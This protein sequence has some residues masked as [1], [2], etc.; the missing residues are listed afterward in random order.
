MKVLIVD[1]EKPVRE[2]IRY[3]VPWDK[4][5]IS[6]VYEATNGQEATAIMQEQQP[7]VVFTDMRMPLMD[8]AQ[9]LEWLH[10]HYPNTKTI[11][12]SGYQDFKYVKP[13]IVYGGTDYLLKPLNSRQLIEAAEHAFELWLAEEEERRLVRRQTMQLNVLRPLYWDKVLSDLLSGQG[14]F[15]EVKP[16]LCGELA[17]PENASVC[18]IAVISLQGA[19]CRLLE[20]LH[21]DAGLASFVL[22]NVCNELLSPGSQGFAFR[23]WQAGAEVVMLFWAEGVQEAEDLLRRINES[24]LLTYGIQMDI[25]LSLAQPLPEG[26]QTA[27]L[28][29]R[30]ALNG[31]NLLQKEER[32]HR[33]KEL[34]PE[35]GP[36]EEFA[37]EPLLEKLRL[38]VLSGDDDKMEQAAGE[39][40]GGLAGMSVLTESRMQR[41]QEEILVVLTRWRPEAE[42]AL[43]LCYDREGLF[44]AEDWGNQLKA[45]LLQLSRGNPQTPDARL[46]QE[47]REYLN[48]NY[49]SDMTL[50]HIAERFFIS[51]EN[52]SRKFKGV[53]GENLSDYLT[54]L[55]VDKAKALL[56]HTNLRLSQ[57]AELVGYEDEKYFSRV[58]KKA[59]GQTPRE[60]RRQ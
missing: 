24:M 51:R 19:H 44:S 11:V 3:F 34:A 50:Q 59:T 35:K 8:G 58:F 53:T 6:E 25:G 54:G 10:A 32:I 45:L 39:W 48:Q 13:A 57:I 60:Y 43:T 41:L 36:G 12:I 31:R 17:M 27:F 40:A 7:A 20:R 55:R 22:A 1:D 21:G 15:L 56:Q 42:P 16:A 9:L 47:I 37:A 28:Q 2:A 49:A 26:L 23:S 4:Y 46:V 33:Y 38:A 52:V 14:A 30:E 5:Q 29:A 18:R